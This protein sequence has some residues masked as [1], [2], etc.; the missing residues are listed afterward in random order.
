MEI[1][2]FLLRWITLVAASVAVACSFA[3]VVR[4]RRP[5]SSLLLG[6]TLLLWIPIIDG[7][8]INAITAPVVKWLMRSGIA[9]S[10]VFASFRPWRYVPEVYKRLFNIAIA[11]FL[12]IFGVL[13]F[14]TFIIKQTDT[15]IGSGTRWQSLLFDAGHTLSA[16]MMALLASVAYIWMTICGKPPEDIDLP[17]PGDLTEPPE[18]P[19]GPKEPEEH[20][21]APADKSE[22]FSTESKSEEPEENEASIEE[23]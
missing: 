15:A 1:L 19:G 21:E 12:L 23:S 8:T 5:A 22:Q 14:Q 11:G 6:A 16:V 3:A 18:A 7:L 4:G 9:I 10:V 2:T 17:I 13:I 20:P